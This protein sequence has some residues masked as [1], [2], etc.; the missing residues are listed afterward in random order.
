MGRHPAAAAARRS[1]LAGQRLGPRGVHRVRA[2]VGPDHAAGDQRRRPG[3]VAL[4]GLEHR[5][6]RVRLGHRVVVHEPDQVGAI[7]QGQRHAVGEPA[8]AAGVAGQLG[9]PRRGEPGA[10]RRRGAVGRG[11]VDHDHRIRRAALRLHRGQRLQQQLPPVV[12]DHDGDHPG[13]LQPLAP[14][15]RSRA[16]GRPVRGRPRL[17]PGST[18]GPGRRAT[19]GPGRGPTSGRRLAGAAA[20][21]G[22]LATSPGPGSLEFPPGQDAQPAHGR[23]PAAELAHRPLDR[24]RDATV[25]STRRASPRAPPGP[26]C[27]RAAG[28]AWW[29]WLT[30]I[31]AAACTAASRTCSAGWSRDRHPAR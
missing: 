5:P 19:S 18:S 15:R 7:G 17:W 27:G 29:Y 1:A 30:T 4:P 25:D 26:A 12:G 23:G 16:R 31:A 8:R 9:Q 21:S 13:R 11:V 10:Y 28:C 3:R 20:G 2:P 22:T 14:G 24:G 6:Q